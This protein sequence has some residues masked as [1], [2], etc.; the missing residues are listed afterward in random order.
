VAAC[1]V[2]VPTGAAAPGF[3]PHDP[4]RATVGVI[5]PT[6][7]AA[8]RTTQDAGLLS[9]AL[10][11][12][13]LT[14][15]VEYASVESGVGVTIARSMV[16]DGIRLLLVGAVGRRDGVRIE[17]VADRAGAEV[18]E[19]GGV[20]LGGN[21]PYYVSFDYR[22]VGR[23]QAQTMV[24]CLRARGVTQPRIILVDGGLDVDENAVLMA[25]GA[26]QVLDPLVSAGQV[27]LAQETTVRGWDI[28]R[29]APAFE[30]ALDASDGR[31]DGVIA[32]NDEIADAVIG[33]LRRRELPA[34]LVAGQGPGIRGLRNVV[35]GRQSMTVH[36]DPR[37][38]AD[39]AARLAAAV[40]SG[41]QRALASAPLTPFADPLAPSRVIAGVL[42]PVQAFTQAD[43][44]DVAETTGV[45]T[46]DLCRG[47]IG[48]C[49]AL[50]VG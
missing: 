3:A 7:S 45:T 9:R 37:L 36:T 31:V 29:A 10:S 48:R 25:L 44:G 38:E 33:V 18:V 27:R 5:L 12:Q 43:L 35:A 26:H 8:P 17:R 14:A 30:Q 15:R 41:S 23:L 16:G 1:A 4:V 42:V 39:A 20:D 11:R 34:T 6:A 32:A 47:M 28:A 22:D 24:D 49:A 46:D 50:G 2:D 13:G 40:L 19:Y 21:A